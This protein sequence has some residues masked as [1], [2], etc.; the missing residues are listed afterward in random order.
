MRAW[1]LANKIILKTNPGTPILR[2]N[3]VHMAGE[4][5]DEWQVAALRQQKLGNFQLK[6]EVKDQGETKALG[7]GKT[8]SQGDIRLHI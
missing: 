2:C 3:A 1:Q 4:S 6:Y 5:G 8:K 7:G